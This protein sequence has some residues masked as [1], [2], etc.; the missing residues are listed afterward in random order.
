MSPGVTSEMARETE[1]MTATESRV[2]LATYTYCFPGCG[3]KKLSDCSCSGGRAAAP[4]AAAGAMIAGLPPV[5]AGRAPA[6][7]A[8]PPELALS[9][10]PA[11]ELLTLPEEQPQRAL[12]STPP[13]SPYDLVIAG[14]SQQQLLCRTL[15]PG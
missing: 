14:S 9:L 11:F 13:M 15:I 5:A 10:P 12:T 3:D 6:P 2:G 4:V 7:K 8:P 1:S